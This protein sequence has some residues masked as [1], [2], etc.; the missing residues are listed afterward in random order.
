MRSSPASRRCGVLESELQPLKGLGNRG[1]LAVMVNRPRLL[2]WALLIL[3][4][5]C[6]GEPDTDGASSGAASV[7]ASSSAVSGDTTVPRAPT[8]APDPPLSKEQLAKFVADKEQQPTRAIV[9]TALLALAE[10]GFDQFGIDHKCAALKDYN[11]V[12]RRKT[13]DVRLFG[14]VGLAHLRHPSP[15][16]RFQA[17]FEG[18]IAA[19]AFDADEATATPYLEALR[20]EADP[21]VLA[22]M[23]KNGVTGARKSAALRTFLLGSSDHANSHVREVSARLLGDADVLPQ[24]PEAFEKLIEKAQ[25]DPDGH[26]RATACASLGAT[27]DDRAMPVFKA[28][29]EDDSAPDEVRNGCFEGV[30]QSWASPIRSGRVAMRTTTRWSSS[31]RSRAGR[32]PRG[33]ASGGSGGRSPR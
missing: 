30:V 3:A 17:S 6:G 29:L 13:E 15:A 1:T 19:F 24:V 2:G 27:Q 12:A 8:V 4:A 7:A 10:C 26:V 23:L 18:S 25:R 5:A 11:E 20:G 32:R 22:N 16:V 28:V 14:S 9:E 21:L 31:P 33:G